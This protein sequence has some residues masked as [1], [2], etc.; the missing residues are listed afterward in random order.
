MRRNLP[1]T[2]RENFYQWND[3]KY[4]DIKTTFPSQEIIE[5]RLRKKNLK[6]N[7][8]LNPPENENENNWVYEVMRN[9]LNELNLFI[10]QFKEVCTEKLKPEM[11]IQ[12]NGEPLVFASSAFNPVKHVPPIDYMVLT[13]SEA[14]S[15]LVNSEI[16]RNNIQKGTIKEIKNCARRLYRIFAFCYYHHKEILISYEKK[17]HLCER[18]T[19]FLKMYGL[20]EKSNFYIPDTFFK[21]ELK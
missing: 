2:K 9:F 1:G 17:T 21:E 5:Q 14:T 13:L 7:D 3:V 16:N 4:E 18:Y 8:F 10:L 12:V 19:K 15:I 20:M 6:I 11:G